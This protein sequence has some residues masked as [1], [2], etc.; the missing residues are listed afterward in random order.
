MA[1]YGHR[2]VVAARAAI[3]LAV[4]AMLTAG[5]SAAAT[6]AGSASVTSSTPQMSPATSYWS[7]GSR[8]MCRLAEADQVT[9]IIVDRINNG[10]HYSFAFPSQVVVTDLAGIRSVIT[11]LCKLPNDTVVNPPADHGVYYMLTFAPVAPTF[12]QILIEATG[13]GAVAG[14]GTPTHAV[15]PR[16]W[17][18]L[19]KALGIAPGHPAHAVRM[20]QGSLPYLASLSR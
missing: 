11:A 19:G 15:T 13:S 12:P 20:L 17:L 3:A 7:T 8:L 2:A 16:F 1:R 4:L 18:A 14:V 10:N 6:A 5:C 9:T